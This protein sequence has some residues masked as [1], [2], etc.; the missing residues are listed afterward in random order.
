M[1]DDEG[2]VLIRKYSSRNNEQLDLVDFSLFLLSE[3]NGP[4]NKAHLPLHQDMTRPLSEYFIASSHNTYVIRR[5]GA[6]GAARARGKLIVFVVSIL[7]ANISS[8]S[9]NRYLLGDQ[10]K[11][12]S[13][14]EGYIRSLLEGCRCVERMYSCSSE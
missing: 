5:R 7:F 10:L 11:G 12:E 9:P 14:V 2:V 4:L 3:D 1:S 6:T 13:S 8:P